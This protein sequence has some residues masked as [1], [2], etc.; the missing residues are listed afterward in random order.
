MKPVCVKCQ[1][2]YKIKK[3]GIT[4]QEMMPRTGGPTP[5]GTQAPEKWKSYKLWRGDLYACTGCGHEIVT[6]FGNMPF[7]EH[8]QEQYA[9]D[10]AAH[11]PYVNINDC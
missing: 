3:S 7:A 8:Y 11:P 4:V 9:D 2:F 10:L 5:A 6:G 1:R